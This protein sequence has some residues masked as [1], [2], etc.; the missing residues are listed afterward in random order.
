[1]IIIFVARS[2]APVEQ[3][4]LMKFV[5][6][7][8]ER[9]GLE[10]CRVVFVPANVFSYSLNGLHYYFKFESGYFVEKRSNESSEDVLLRLQ[11]GFKEMLRTYSEKP[12]GCFV[13]VLSA[14]FVQILVREACK[15]LDTYVDPCSMTVV[16][17]SDG[18]YV[19]TELNVK[20]GPA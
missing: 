14:A 10:C 5:N 2:S 11:D 1:M 16:E 15:K 18:R 6:E 7:R 8:A 20:P 3:E 19:I 9:E 12:I 13:V 4:R 17:V